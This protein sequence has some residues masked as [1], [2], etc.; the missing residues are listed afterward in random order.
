MPD[1][2]IVF[3]AGTASTSGRAFD[4][5]RRAQAEVRDWLAEHRTVRPADL[6]PA[7]RTDTELAELGASDMMHEWVLILE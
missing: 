2:T 1:N 7:R 5:I 4:A 6:P 3:N